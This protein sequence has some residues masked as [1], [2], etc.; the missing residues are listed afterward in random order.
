MILKL[1]G[2]S[3]SNADTLATLLENALRVLAIIEAKI[4]VPE[5]IQLE[6]SALPPFTSVDLH[7]AEEGDHALISIW[8]RTVEMLWQASMN[9]ELKPASWE[10]VTIRLLTWRSMLDSE[11]SPIGE[12]ARMSVVRS[13]S[14]TSA[15]QSLNDV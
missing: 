2:T 11:Q 13:M 14:S 3:R 10:A 7:D 8:G 12:W 9:F 6:E 15:M 5:S 1:H 4:D